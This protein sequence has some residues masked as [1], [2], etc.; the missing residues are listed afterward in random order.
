MRNPFKLW[1]LRKWL[2]FGFLGALALTLVIGVWAIVLNQE[3]SERLEKGWFLP[4]LELYS[5]EMR[6]SL[7][8]HL[9]IV[10]FSEQLV[11]LGYQ[12]VG[13]GE[14]LRGREYSLWTPEFCQQNLSIELPEGTFS[15]VAFNSEPSPGQTLFSLLALDSA[16]VLLGVYQGEPALAVSHI[17]LEPYM[18]AQYYGEQPILRDV[19]KLSAIPLSCLQAVTAIEDSDFLTHAGVSFTGTLRALGRNLTSGRYAQGGSTITQ[20]LVKNFF[21]TAE[22]TIKRKVTEQ[23]MAFLLESRFTKDEILENYLNVIYMGQNGPFQIRGYSSAARHY[24]NKRVSELDLP[25]CALLA[26]LVNSPGRYSPFG[27]PERALKRRELVLSKMHELGMVSSG[28]KQEAEQKP[29]PTRPP[30]LL[31]EPAPYYVQAV[32]K[33]LEDEG[34]DASQGLKIYTHLNPTAQEIGQKHLSAEVVRLEKEFKKIT[35]LKEKGKNLQAA[36]L[37]VDLKTN[38]IIALIGGREFKKSQYNRAIDSRRQ[39]GSVMKPFVYLAA[40]ETLTTEGDPYEPT[41]LISDEPLDHRYERQRWRPSN[42]DRKFH[43]IIPLYVGLKDSLNVSTAR[44]GIDVGLDSIVDVSKRLGI[45]S[46]VKALPSLSLGAFEIGVLE[47]ARAY[48]A[49]A[50]MG[51][52]QEVRLIRRVLNGHGEELWKPDAPTKVVANPEAVARLVGM[53][54]QTIETGSARS[55][56]W[57]GF[58]HPAAGKTGTT[59]DTKDAWFVGFTPHNLTVVW[60]GYDDNTS[61]GLTGSNG[62]VPLWTLFMKDFATTYPPDDFTWPEGVSERELTVTELMSLFQGATNM[63][64]PTAPLKLIF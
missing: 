7:G 21:L 47:V 4:P 41:T 55:V 61:H 1:P 10:A 49:L 37:S 3:I 51:T 15:C 33:K 14:K 54:K 62:A 52:L 13:P 2:I 8:Q 44:L 6:L 53:M 56:R 40:L 57:R 5:D 48:A 45:E 34:V 31:S 59:S 12:K 35:A 58:S 64:L 20:Q 46:P 25:E 32:L 19:T 29:L 17:A 11:A 23:I 26:S 50:R 18:F 63:E 16:S 60:V 43:G 27:Q 9:K 28:E 22:K 39:I 36:L 38:G 30:R 24:F 42:Y